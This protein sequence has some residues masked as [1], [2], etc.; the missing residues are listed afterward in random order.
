MSFYLDF[1][2]RDSLTTITLGTAIPAFDTKSK[3]YDLMVPFF[4]NKPRADDL[5]TSKMVKASKIIST[6]GAFLA[7]V[8][9][10]PLSLNFKPEIKGL[11]LAIACLNMASFSSFLMWSSKDMIDHVFYSLKTSEHHQIKEHELCRKISVL[12][13]SVISGLA[14]QAPYFFLAWKYNP[15]NKY[16]IALSGLDVM[17]PIYSLY[18]L[19]NHT[20]SKYVCSVASGKILKVK[21]Y[22]LERLDLRLADIINGNH[23][24]NELDFEL[25]GDLTTLD[26]ISHFFLELMHDPLDYEVEEPRLKFFK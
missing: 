19:F 10:L 4:E 7:R 6:T 9:L 1:Y 18:L 13:L 5:R 12:V 3:V 24:E 22:F 20:F 16:M 25:N 15:N 11:G 8:P 26:K 2:G 21:Q 17:P 14:S 23:Y